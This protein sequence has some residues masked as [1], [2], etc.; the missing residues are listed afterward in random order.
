MKVIVYSRPDGRV[1]VVNP[2]PRHIAE[3]MAGG[4]TE[5]E[6]IASVQ[7]KDVP[8]D[9]T[10]VEIM[11]QSLI[12]TSREFRNAWEK[13][14][15][16]V[17]TINMPKAR[18]IHAKKIIAAKDR[19]IIVLQRRADEATIE[20]R[21]ADATQTANDKTA[22]EGLNLATIATRIAGAANPTAL[23]AIWPTELQEFKPL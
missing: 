17:P 14:G 19:A 15:A 18:I 16:G 2:A 13:S 7:A 20:G 4:I 21:A 9:A 5:D 3:L 6:A 12:L 23:S 1:S 22:I 10:N 11:E 8:L